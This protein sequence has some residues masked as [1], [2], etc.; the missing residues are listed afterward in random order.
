M[1]AVLYSK[2]KNRSPE[3]LGSPMRQI[4][5][6][7]DGLVQIDDD[8]LALHPGGYVSPA[9]RGAN[10]KIVVVG[11]GN[12]LPIEDSHAFNLLRNARTQGRKVEH[13]FLRQFLNVVRCQSVR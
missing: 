10:L 13:Q 2:R 1:L 6:L 8:D 4:L 11:N 12:R 9:C 7:L 3:G 5:W